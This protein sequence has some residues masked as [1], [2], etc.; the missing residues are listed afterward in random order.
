MTKQKEDKLSS[1]AVYFGLEIPAFALIEIRN[2]CWYDCKT[3]PGNMF[4]ETPKRKIYRD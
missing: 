1:I 3:K 2:I 4:I